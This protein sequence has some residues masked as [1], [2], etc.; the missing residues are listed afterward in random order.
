MS[1]SLN[2]IVNN[3][4]IIVNNNFSEYIIIYAGSVFLGISCI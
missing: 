2:Y 4:Y 3:N 1:S